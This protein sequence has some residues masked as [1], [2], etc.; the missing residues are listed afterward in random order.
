M[1]YFVHDT[2]IVDEGAMI[3]NGTKIWH[4][5]HVRASAE[6]GE[7]VVIG[8][9]VYIDAHVKIGSYSKIQNKVSVYDGVTIEEEVFVGPH[10]VFTNDMKPR[11]QGEW[12]IVKTLVKK[13]ASIGARAVIVCGTTIGSYSM[14][15]AGSVVTK[16]V[17]AHA[18]VFGN[19]ARFQGVV[20][21][22]GEKIAG[23]EAENGGTFTCPSCHRKVDYDPNKF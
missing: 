16:S 21:Y 8:N 11:A 1:D 15:G 6:I 3:G 10:A 20:C 17:P 5:S 18:L 14:I 7:N 13:G 19:P 22:C 12:K 4:F 2:A 9:G 23:K